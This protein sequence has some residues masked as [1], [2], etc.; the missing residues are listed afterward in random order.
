M[1]KLKKRKQ[2]QQHI[3]KR[4][5]TFKKFVQKFGHN[6]KGVK[7]TEEHKHKIGEANKISN[8]RGG[9]NKT[10]AGYILIKTDGHPLAYRGGYVREHRLI[11][12]KI[13][14]RYLKRKEA[15]HHRNGIKHDN[16]PQNLQL[17]V[18]TPHYGEIN[19][20]YCN[21]KFLIR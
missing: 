19:C 5:K 6:R 1:H 12:E 15:V 11:M 9:K 8:F 4:V 7:L 16:R 20:P 13:L 3:A 18:G 21:K 10:M 14:G 17:V 2:T